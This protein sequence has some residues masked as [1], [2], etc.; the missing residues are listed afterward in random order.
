M[1]KRVVIFSILAVFICFEFAYSQST[2]SLT[3]VF[4]N[5][6]GGRD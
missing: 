2:N 5:L 3:S 4:K 6:D 1:F